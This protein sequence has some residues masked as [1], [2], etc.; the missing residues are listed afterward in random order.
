MQRKNDDIPD[1]KSAPAAV[2]Y[3]ERRIEPRVPHRAIIVMPFGDEVESRFEEA[4]MLDCSLH[5]IGLLIRRPLRPRTRFFV[6]LRL[7]K[8]ALVIYEVKHC[9]QTDDG[10]RVGADLKG[11]SG[12]DTDRE[13][14]A[15]AILTALLKS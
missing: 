7:T 15:E 1:V 2:N 8:L 11:V 6:K 4:E 12:S 5:G 14:S 9:T 13:A 3:A 10:Y